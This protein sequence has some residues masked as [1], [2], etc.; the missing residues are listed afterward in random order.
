MMVIKNPHEKAGEHTLGV[1]YNDGKVR[2][3]R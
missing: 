2:R 1:L 3:R